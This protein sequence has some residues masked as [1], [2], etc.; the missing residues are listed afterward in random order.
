MDVSAFDGEVGL[1]GGAVAVLE[2]IV[3]CEAVDDSARLL[4]DGVEGVVSDC[5]EEEEVDDEEGE[6]EEEEVATVVVDEE[7]EEEEVVVVESADGIYSR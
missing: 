6:E 7:E 3:D 2:L 5:E 4:A 1:T